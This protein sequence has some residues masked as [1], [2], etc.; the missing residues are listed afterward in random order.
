MKNVIKPLAKSVLIT[1]G[2]T[3]VA[4]KTYEM[5]LFKRKFL[6]LEVVWTGI[7]NDN[8]DN[9]KCKNGKYHKNS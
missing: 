4:S 2:Y 3:A 5:Q 8:I 9:F 7:E 6:A 1:L